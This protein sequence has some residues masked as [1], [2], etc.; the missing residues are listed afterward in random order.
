MDYEDEEPVV[1]FGSPDSNGIVYSHDEEKDDMYEPVLDNVR[2]QTTAGGDDE[3]YEYYY[4][5]EDGNVIDDKGFGQ[6]SD[7]GDANDNILHI[8]MFEAD[9]AS[10]GMRSVVNDNNEEDS[11]DENEQYEMNEMYNTQRTTANGSKVNMKDD[12]TR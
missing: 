1:P 8:N 5:D 3:D 2:N 11:T 12:L 7:G 10:T 6:T 4:E 9:A